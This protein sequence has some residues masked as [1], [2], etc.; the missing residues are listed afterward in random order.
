[1][2]TVFKFVVWGGISLDIR[3]ENL[4]YGDALHVAELQNMIS[5]RIPDDIPPQMTNGI[6]GYLHSNVLFNIYTSKPGICL[7]NI[8]CMSDVYSLR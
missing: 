5:E 3:S 8:S 6:Y 1:M 7:K 2:I 4:F